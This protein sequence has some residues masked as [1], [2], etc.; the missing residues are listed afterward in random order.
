MTT[1]APA[2]EAT[3]EAPTQTEVD[4]LLAPEGGCGSVIGFSAMAVRAL[5]GALCIKRKE[6]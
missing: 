3:T 1:E 4:T 6:N 5:G 2:E